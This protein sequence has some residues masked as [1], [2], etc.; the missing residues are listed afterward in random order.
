VASRLTLWHHNLT[1][2]QAFALEARIVQRLIPLLVPAEGVTRSEAKTYFDCL[3]EFTHLLGEGGLGNVS[4][5]DAKSKGKALHIILSHNRKLFT[6]KSS[7]AALAIIPVSD[8]LTESG[9]INYVP[10]PGR[11]DGDPRNADVD[12]LISQ[13]VN[14]LPNIEIVGEAIVYPAMADNQYILDRKQD[15]DPFVSKEFFSRGLWPESGLQP[16]DHCIPP[17]FLR[18]ILEKWRLSLRHRGL[19]GIVESYDTFLC[20]MN[21]VRNPA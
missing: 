16:P 5:A 8:A 18:T 1:R 15:T 4:L 12:L 11:F 20:G 19:A 2:E 10:C 13:G 17:V 3:F 9:L 6:G 21:L 7:P 14:S